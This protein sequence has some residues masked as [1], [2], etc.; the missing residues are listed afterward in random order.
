MDKD[1]LVAINA[2]KTVR[3]VKNF[4]DRAGHYRYTLEKWV[5][6]KRCLFWTKPGFWH[7]GSRRTRFLTIPPVTT[8]EQIV[9]SGWMTHYQLL[10][11]D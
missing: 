2:E 6:P 9:V 5:P 8:K 4:D 10:K 7:N 3:V 11:V 1:E